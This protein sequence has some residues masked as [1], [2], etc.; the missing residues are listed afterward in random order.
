[1]DVAPSPEQRAFGSR[2]TALTWSFLAAGILQT[3]VGLGL[4]WVNGLAAA[5]L[6]GNGINFTLQAWFGAWGQGVVLTDEA[7]QIRGLRRRTMPWQ[8]LRRVTLD[9]KSGAAGTGPY[10]LLDPREGTTITSNA[11][12]GFEGKIGDEL[13]AALRTRAASGDHKFE[14]DVRHPTWH[15]P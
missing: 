9:W 3:I 15:R 12:G 11:I 2:P 1:M 7:L 14:V 13:E 10:L 5:I 6:L 8:D 4:L